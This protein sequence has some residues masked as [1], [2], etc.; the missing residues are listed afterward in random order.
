[1][2]GHNQVEASG[3]IPTIFIIIVFFVLNKDY[4]LNLNMNFRTLLAPTIY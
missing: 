1:M 3:L 2:L 4:G